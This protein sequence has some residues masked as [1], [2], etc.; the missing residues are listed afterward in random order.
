MISTRYKCIT[1]AYETLNGKLARKIPG[2][3]GDI[4]ISIVIRLNCMRFE[5]LTAVTNYSV[6]PC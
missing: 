2:A 6:T 4:I 3:Y 1:N 5:P